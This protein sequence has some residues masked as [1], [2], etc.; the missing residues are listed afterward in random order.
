MKK[1]LHILE[2]L[3]ILIIILLLG[4]L[5]IKFIY[6]IKHENVDTSYIWNIN[7]S[8]LVVT[9]GSKEGHISLNNNSID[10]DVT[11]SKEKEFYEFLID[12]NNTGT[13]AAEITDLS[14]NV[15]NPDNIL[16]YTVTYENGISIDKGDKLESNETKTIKVRIEYPTQKSKVYKSLNLKLSLNIEYSPIY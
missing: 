12:V 4:L 16:K 15:E 3:I 9:E 7:F 10:L 5:T 14:I 6:H 1:Q 8:N 11:L 2:G 13:L